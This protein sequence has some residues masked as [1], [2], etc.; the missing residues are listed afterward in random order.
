MWKA[1][2]QQMRVQ[3]NDIWQSCV[4]TAGIGAVGIIIF[5]IICFFQTDVEEY[6]PLGTI[7]AGI[8]M[9]LF[10][11]AFIMIQLP[12]YFRIEVSMGC[13][14]KHFFWAFLAASLVQSFLIY[15]TVLLVHVGDRALSRVRQPGMKTVIEVMPYLLKWGLPAVIGIVVVSML[16]GILVM[17]FGKYAYVFLWGVWMIACLGFPRVVDAVV[18]APESVF[19][20]IGR[21]IVS[22]VVSVPLTAW[23]VA[24]AVFLAAALIGTYVILRKQPV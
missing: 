21:E 2:K 24:A 18:E 5:Q 19:G 6:V 23:G 17:R 11:M 8:G 16:C 9:I 12:V 13:I 3:W 15:G 22:F 14:R 7:M 20:R 10:A 4:L 1:F